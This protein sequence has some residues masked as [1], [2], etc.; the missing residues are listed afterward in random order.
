[1]FLKSG[2]LDAMFFLLPRVASIKQNMTAR[3]NIQPRKIP[4]FLCIYV[5]KGGRFHRRAQHR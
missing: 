2:R 1:M 5:N 3:C 4:A